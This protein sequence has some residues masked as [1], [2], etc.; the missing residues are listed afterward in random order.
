MVCASSGN[1][2]PPQ[3]SQAMR[4]FFFFFAAATVI[5]FGFGITATSSAQSTVDRIVE[6][7]TAH[8]CEEG[9]NE[10]CS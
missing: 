4:T 6:S 9:F 1:N 2:P 3:L 8:Y 7:R 5:G 10:F